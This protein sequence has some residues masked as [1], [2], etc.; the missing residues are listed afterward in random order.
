MRKLLVPF[1]VS[2]LVGAVQAN[3]NSKKKEID[4]LL[5]P[6]AVSYALSISYEKMPRT[7]WKLGY[8]LADESDY[9]ALYDYARLFSEEFQKY[10][11]AFIRK[12]RLASI[13]LV[14]D[15][16]FQGQLRTAVPDYGKEIL[17]L[18]FK[19]GSYAPIY[20]RH[21]IHHEFYHLIEEEFNR[22]PYW[23]DTRWARLN[24]K[25]FR[26]GKGGDKVQSDS[27][28]YLFTHPAPGFINLYAMS[29]LEE[30][31]AEIYASLFV[32]PEYERITSWTEK[33]PILFS[34]IKYMKR[35]LERLDQTMDESYWSCP[36]NTSTRHLGRLFVLANDVVNVPPQ[37]L[38]S[39]RNLLDRQPFGADVLS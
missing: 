36:R 9:A 2:I 27:S 37:S 12:T 7:S 17:I 10:P 3:A 31:K 1:L 20:Q 26:Y 30:D 33:D 34:K 21:V 24:P 14:K 16:S 6:L 23:K 4:E 35:F 13:V 11:R 22:T 38:G 15:L 29:A 19:R 28:V 39:F 25:R 8:A 32:C 5:R 18:D